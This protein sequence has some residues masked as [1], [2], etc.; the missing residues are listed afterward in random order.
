VTRS[1]AAACGQDRTLETMGLGPSGWL[2]LDTSSRSPL[3]F[4]SGLT[5][6]RFPPLAD[7]ASPSD[8]RDFISIY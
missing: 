1:G 2:D 6:S 3:Y 8:L 4:A 5:S 7:V